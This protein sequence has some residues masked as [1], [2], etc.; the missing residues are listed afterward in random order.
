[1]PWVRRDRLPTGRRSRDE[2]DISGPAK[3]AAGRAVEGLPSRVPSR[4][5]VPGA[6]AE[7]LAAAGRWPG[8]SAP[9]PQAC[10][11]VTGRSERNSGTRRR[12]S[13]AGLG[14]RCAN[15]GSRAA[16]ARLRVAAASGRTGE[17]Q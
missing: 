14:R 13:T 6:P 8:A 9:A 3:K 12:S 17:W 11:W 15:G 16:G 4:P 10:G 5:A 2:P 7:K 1:M